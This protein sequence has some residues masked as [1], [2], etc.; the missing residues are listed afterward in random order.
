M[1]LSESRWREQKVRDNITIL[2]YSALNTLFPPSDKY[3]DALNEIR[4]KRSIQLQYKHLLTAVDKNNKQAIFKNMETDEEVAVKYDFFH[5]CPPHSP[6]EFVSN[7]PLADATGFC[8]ANMHTL[9]HP[10]YHNVF[11]VGDSAGLAASKT[12]ASLFSQVPVM[13]HNMIMMEKNKPLGAVYNGY[14]SCPL[15]VG[16]KKIML[17]EFKYERKDNETFYINQ[18]KPSRL[19]YFMKKSIFP[20]VYFNLV[21]KG[22]WYGNR[23]IFKPKY[24]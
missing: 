13:V 15:F 6:Q 20:W 1:F 14:G 2:N 18:N 11:S 19:F 16:D 10:D 7:S 24:F 22:K 8:E 17:A 3:S 5:I 4:I 23:T 12:A 21:P 9:R